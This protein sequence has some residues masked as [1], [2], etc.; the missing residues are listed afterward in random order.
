M[1]KETRQRLEAVEARLVAL[2]SRPVATLE[3]KP[4]KK[5]NRRERTPEEKAEKVRQLRAG[6]EAARKRRE[7]EAA[8]QAA[9][10]PEARAQEDAERDMAEAEPPEDMTGI[11][12]KWDTL[13][14]PQKRKVAKKA[15]VEG[16]VAS[17]TWEALHEADKSA[18]IKAQ[19]AK[20]EAKVAK[21][22]AK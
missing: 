13:T 11:A 3:V 2:E 7:A 6:K 19:N 18:I 21:E 22:E 5:A 10:S 9:V 16:R 15:G 20:A 1:D 17:S 8:P 12:T 14:I 4:K